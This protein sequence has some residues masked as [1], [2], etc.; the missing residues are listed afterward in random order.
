MRALHVAL[1]VLWGGLAV[2]APRGKTRLVILPAASTGRDPAEAKIVGTIEAEIVDAARKLPDLEIA[3]LDG[4]KLRGPPRDVRADPRP[5]A[6][7]QA[8]A[9]EL[10]AELALVVE[11]QPLGEG[12]AV[13]LQ[14]V[15]A[16]SK[17]RGSTTVAISGEAL[18]AG[19]TGRLLR[20]G[21]VQL[22]D[23]RGYVGRI[24]LRID[25]KGA[26]TEIDGR[27][28][29]ATGPLE[30]S[31]G[32]HAV[33]VTHP[34]YRDF[35]RFVDVGFDRTSTETVALAAFPLTEGEMNEKRRAAAGP[36]PKVPWYRSGWALGITGAVLV[37][38]TFGIVYGLRPGIS[39]D[40]QV[41]Y[42]A[43]PSP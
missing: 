9:K 7:A 17:V 26:E 24:E 31:V 33:R 40:E 10:S 18:H 12:A 6:R 41:H 5:S 38:A 30:L 42:R 2:A 1:A 16:G 29:S 8:L 25:V 35:L 32:T 34:A 11:T 39:A 14:I 27:K 37:G 15:E 20:G 22:L 4:G 28:M 23:P 21:I 36:R 3:N 13:Y 19:D 43:V